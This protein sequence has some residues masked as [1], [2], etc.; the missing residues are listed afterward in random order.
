MAQKQILQPYTDTI[1]DSVAEEATYRTSR[2]SPIPT[3]SLSIVPDLPEKA[4]SLNLAKIELL[5]VESPYNLTHANVEYFK[6]LNCLSDLLESLMT[7]VEKSHSFEESFLAFFRHRLDKLLVVIYLEPTTKKIDLNIPL[8]TS[9]AELLEVVLSKLPNNSQMCDYLQ[10]LNI[11]GALFSPLIFNIPVTVNI[12]R[13]LNEFK[14]LS[15]RLNE[16]RKIV[17]TSAGYLDNGSQYSILDYK[18]KLTDEIVCTIVKHC[19]P[20]LGMYQYMYALLKAKI[21]VLPELD[22]LVTNTERVYDCIS[23]AEIQGM[24]QVFLEVA[25]LIQSLWIEVDSEVCG[26]I[27]EAGVG[28]FNLQESMTKPTVIKNSMFLPMSY[29]VSNYK[30]HLENQIPKWANHMFVESSLELIVELEENLVKSETNLKNQESDNN[31]LK[32][33][34]CEVASDTNINISSNENEVPIQV[35]DETLQIV[36]TAS[37]V[38]LDSIPLKNS[39]GVR[40]L[41][42]QKLG[43]LLGTPKK[44]H[45][46][47]HWKRQYPVKL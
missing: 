47:L 4:L 19:P 10:S 18:I 25:R 11:L 7:I 12:L 44:S 16:T 31:S 14:K 35:S 41:I 30:F 46:W 20:G 29:D 26:S 37:Q 38:S 21:N 42:R 15:Q 28:L 13:L 34:R 39:P 8:E 22:I 40:D 45:W 32:L 24:K 33:A 6:M 2:T 36:Q 23:E 9:P 5:L 3:L 17:V 43:L 27:L 1:M